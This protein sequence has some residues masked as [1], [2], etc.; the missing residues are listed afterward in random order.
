MSITQRK[1]LDDIIIYKNTALLNL[2]LT[3]HIFSK[4]FA[5]NKAI[6]KYLENKVCLDAKKISNETGRY[7]IKNG[8]TPK[9]SPLAP[10][11]KIIADEYFEHI[12]D[13]CN[14]LGYKVFDSHINE[15]EQTSVKD[16]FFINKGA[17]DAKGKL[18]DESFVVLK[19]SKVTHSF[20]VGTTQWFKDSG[21]KLRDD[22]VIVND[23]FTK[24]TIN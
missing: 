13:L 3:A 23:E 7:D 12:K 8:N 9:S 24:S 5:L 21:K 10:E 15:E 6:V 14:V 19:G 1:E 17:I 16:L 2:A 11:D 4:N 20:A 22:G 18:I